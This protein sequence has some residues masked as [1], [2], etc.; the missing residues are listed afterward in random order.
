MLRLGAVPGATPGKWIERW[1]EQHPRQPLEL[2]PLEAADQLRAI[3]AREVDVAI[4]RG[5][6][7][8]DDLH[9]VAL[10][11]E[12]A[13]VVMS[14]DSHLTVADELIPDDLVGEVL[15]TPLD[16]VFGPLELPT[17][18]PNFDPVPTTAD[19]IATVAA[20]VGIAV[21]PMSL[22]RLHHRKDV[23]F[24]RLP[25]APTSPVVLVWLRERDADDIQAF[26][27]ITRGRTER[28]SR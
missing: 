6:V 21:V 12:D 24:R 5:P 13:V 14:A 23:T 26:V 20:G 2:V 17:V 22:A 16:D 8:D 3:R 28:S 18:A 9:R 15:L 19:A 7:S 1:R 25:A 27:G 4:C 11:E 10:Y